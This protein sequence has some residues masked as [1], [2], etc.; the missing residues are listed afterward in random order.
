MSEETPCSKCRRTPYP[1]CEGHGIIPTEALTVRRCPHYYALLVARHLGEEI[2][3]VKHVKET[4]LLQ[5]APTGGKAVVDMTT[6]N[7]L[8]EIP[9]RGL[10]PHLKKVL[11]FKGPDFPFRIVTDEKIKNVFVGNESY[12]NRARDDRDDMDVYN[13]LPDLIGENF[14]LIIVRLGHLGYKNISAAGALKEALM[15]RAMLR[16]ATWLVVDPD[17]P[18][19]HSKNDDV[20]F[21]VH[22]NF[23]PF[24]ITAADPGARRLPQPVNTGM[25]FEEDDEELPDLLPS[26]SR[27][28]APSSITIAMPGDNVRKKPQMEEASGGDLEIDMPGDGQPSKKKR[29]SR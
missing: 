8:L 19:T 7:I 28:E 27:K 10:L 9:W 16:K 2:C 15:H 11:A 20:E 25:S 24:Y 18:W 3:S 14:E 6:Q 26:A 5:A 22:R 29:W 1:G 21:Y 12:K 17:Q 23:K 4:P 13:A